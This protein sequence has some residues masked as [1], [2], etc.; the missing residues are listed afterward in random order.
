MPKESFPL[1]VLPLFLLCGCRSG[2]ETLEKQ[3]AEL[4][5]ELKTAN[6]RLE[7]MERQL[8]LLK[9]V[10]ARL[11]RVERELTMIRSGRQLIPGSRLA[12]ADRNKL[13]KIRRLPKDPTDRQIIE[14][15]GQIGEA[16]AGQQVWG[17][18]DPQVALYEQIG[19]GHL[20]LL[21]PYLA[22]NF[23]QSFHLERALPRLVDERDRELV[24]QSLK[25]YPVLIEAA[26]R[27]GWGKDM[28]KEIFAAFK[29][30]D[31]LPFPELVKHL[32][33]LVQSPEDMKILTEMYIHNRNGHL[34]LRGL[35]QLPGADV[36]K[37]VDQAWKAVQKKEYPDFAMIS[38][39]RDAVQYG[40]NVEA[41][42]YLLK[43]VMISGPRSRDYG[44]RQMAQFLSGLCDFPVY[45]QAALN[46]WYGKNADRIVFDPASG[47]FVLKGK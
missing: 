46:E 27:K 2:N 5:A 30:T 42:R 16:S 19:P 1:F 4:L 31:N 37:L 26:L 8:S 34:L 20:R 39:A 33:E 45:D 43:R 11:L 29:S 23:Q 9:T 13:A 15:I 22:G 17:S 35:K 18:N 36:K 28:K 6:V 25:R 7:R 14:Y 44:I 38:R 47:K 10:D 3:N 41:F 40:R 12:G 32:S 24:R 21:L